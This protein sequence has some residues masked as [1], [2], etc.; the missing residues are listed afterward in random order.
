[1]PTELP[2]EDSKSISNEPSATLPESSKASMAMI[3]QGESS[4]VS[5]PRKGLFRKASRASTKSNLSRTTIVSE[6]EEDHRQSHGRS[7]IEDY[8]AVGE[9]MQMSLG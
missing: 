8:W 5:S 3:D 9:D 1:M 7:G 2:A 4:S 6:E